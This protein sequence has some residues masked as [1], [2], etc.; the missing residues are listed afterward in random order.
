M[1]PELPVGYVELLTQLKTE[2]RSARLRAT[3]VDNT[4]LLELYWT[5][6]K[7]I[8]DRQESEGWGA[9]VVTRLAAD[10]RAEFPDMRGFSPRNLQYMATAAAAWPGPIAQQAAAQLPWGHVMVLLDDSPTRPRGTGT[11]PRRPRTAGPAACWSSRSPAGS[12]IATARH[13]PTSLASCR[14]PIRTW[15]SS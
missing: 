6:G 3:R 8:L 10:L 14:H 2:V 11:P 1:G 5:I 12:V 13:H 7:A 9:R 4:A 15:H